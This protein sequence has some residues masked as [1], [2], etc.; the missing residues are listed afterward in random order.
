MNRQERAVLVLATEMR[1]AME[2]MERV[3]L[4]VAALAVRAGV[5]WPQSDS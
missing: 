5:E 2:A 3:R 4:I 1:V